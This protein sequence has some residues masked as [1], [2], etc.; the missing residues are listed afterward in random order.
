MVI[1]EN[2]DCVVNQQVYVKKNKSELMICGS[3]IDDIQIG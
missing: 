2:E 3:G 1:G